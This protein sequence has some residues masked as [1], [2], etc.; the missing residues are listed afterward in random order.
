V[1]EN[2]GLFYT[3]PKLLNKMEDVE[4]IIEG[5][6]ISDLIDAI[7]INREDTKLSM[8]CATN[9]RVFVYSTGLGLIG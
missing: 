2:A 5:L 1:C 9:I 8:V 6:D 3:R 4:K 7:L